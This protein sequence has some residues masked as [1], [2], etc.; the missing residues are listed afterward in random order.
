M[1]K[2]HK[3]DRKIVAG[4]PDFLGNR[5]FSDPFLNPGPATKKALMRFFLLVAGPGFAPG[6]RGYEPRELLLLHPAMCEHTL[7]TA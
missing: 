2:H 7:Y 4:P 1:K 6:S 3:I 5:R